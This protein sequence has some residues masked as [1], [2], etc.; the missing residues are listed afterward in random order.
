[1]IKSVIY[2]LDDTLYDFITANQY[3]EKALIAEAERRFGIDGARFGAAYAGTYYSVRNAMPADLLALIPEDVGI[4]AMHSRTLRLDLTLT[5]LGLPVLPHAVELYDFY[6][7]TLLDH[8]T[9]EPHLPET[10]QA[11]KAKGLR[12]GVGTNMTARMQYRK[13]IRL[14]LSEWVDFVVT[15]DECVFDKPDPRFFDLVI[16]KAGCPA[17]N[18]LFIGDNYQLDY[19]GARA[20]GLQALWYER[21]HK[22]WNAVEAAPDAVIHDH[23]EVLQYV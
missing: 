1:M 9:R 2:D 14:G 13:L 12:V 20:S 15:S 11:L 19:L 17:E 16:R 3:A 5:R 21:V 23:K 7:E 8:M 22:P 6:W 10:L 4:A 18:C